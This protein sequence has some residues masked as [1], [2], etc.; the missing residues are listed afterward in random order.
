LQSTT[1]RLEEWRLKRRDTENWMTHRQLPQNLRE[2]V[3]QF[4]QYQWLTTHGV[5][6]G[7]ILFSL[8]KDLRRDIQRHLCLDLV[9]RVSP[10]AVVPLYHLSNRIIPAELV[11]VGLV[12]FGKN[13]PRCGYL[14]SLL[15][16]T[17]W[18]IWDD[19]KRWLIVFEEISSTLNCIASC[20]LV[21]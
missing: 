11:S 15:V 20:F 1:L 6:E 8:P 17:V 4:L 14:I 2:R 5:D 3:T 12:S 10:P 7:A 21:L 18:C 16:L 9:R 19:I 13:T